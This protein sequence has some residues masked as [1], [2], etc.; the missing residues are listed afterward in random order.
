MYLL[1]QVK[2]ILYWIA[3]GMQNDYSIK[4]MRVSNESNSQSQGQTFYILLQ[5]IITG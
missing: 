1:H 4:E 3:L 2:D 5:F